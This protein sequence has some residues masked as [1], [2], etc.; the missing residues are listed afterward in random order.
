MTITKP[1]RANV[2]HSS[3]NDNAECRTRNRMAEWQWQV[4]TG[5]RQH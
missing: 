2:N 1:M 4:T 5:A 3:L